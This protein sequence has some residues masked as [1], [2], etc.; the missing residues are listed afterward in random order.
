[1]AVAFRSTF[2]LN[3]SQYQ[4]IRK[5]HGRKIPSL[6]KIKNWAKNLFDENSL[7][8]GLLENKKCFAYWAYPEGIFELYIQ[9]LLATCWSQKPPELIH[10]V[11]GGD[12]GGNKKSN[13]TKIGLFVPDGVNNSQSTKNFLVFAAYDDPESTNTIGLVGNR[14]L[15]FVNNLPHYQIGDTIVGVE[16]LAVGDLKWLPL[17]TATPHHASTE[18]YPICRVTKSKKYLHF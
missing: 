1:M 4:G 2:N 6:K 5:L 9:K 17:V 13:W 14:L 8:S 7:L 18:F 3:D 11:I 12:R 10:I 16:L 15:N